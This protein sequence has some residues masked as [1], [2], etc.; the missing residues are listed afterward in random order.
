MRENVIK[1]RERL[2]NKL[3]VLEKGENNKCMML[4]CCFKFDDSNVACCKNLNSVRV[5]DVEVISQ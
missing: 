1:D 2:N 4:Q 5:P 3:F